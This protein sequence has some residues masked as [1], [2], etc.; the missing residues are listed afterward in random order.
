MN[1]MTSTQIIEASPPRIAR[2]SLLVDVAW[3]A[4][5]F[6]AAGGVRIVPIENP[7]RYFWAPLDAIVFYFLI[8][9]SRLFV[10]VLKENRAIALWPALAAASAIWSV[11][12]ATSF[13]FGLQLLMTILAGVLLCL[14]ADLKKILILLFIGLF[15][16]ALASFAVCLAHLP[17]AIGVNGEWLGV[18]PH[19]NFLGLYMAL[20]VVTAICLFFCRW[21]RFI[22]LSGFMLGVAL[23]LLSRSGTALL[24]LV[25]CFAIFA[26]MSA[27]RYG[28]NALATLTGLT[29]ASAAVA[30]FVVGSGEF[31]VGTKIL[32]ALGKDPTFTGRTTIWD[33]GW[34]QF[35]RDPILGVGYRAYWD[36]P[37]TSSGM[38]QAV[39]KQNLPHFHNNFLDVA[40]GLGSVGFLLFLAGLGSTVATVGRIYMRRP[41]YLN[42]WPV[43]FLCHTLVSCLAEVPI[44]LNHSLFQVLLIVATSAR[45]LRIAR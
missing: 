42:L 28:N 3:I 1:V 18:F 16:T 5:I 11:I 44:Y 33:F 7:E 4:F 9:Q 8:R 32:A 38:L 24:S 22:T 2:S 26:F 29:I 37:Q 23:I 12:P 15:L 35:L 41:D 13:Y 27:A 17:R 14:Y 31:D 40:V 43:L 39:M 45:R 10:G 21:R 36:S 25:S 6:G 30:I 34:E 19:K 20:F